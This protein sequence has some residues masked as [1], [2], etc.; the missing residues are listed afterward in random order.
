MYR[1]LFYPTP[2][3]RQ[4][5]RLY[6]DSRDALDQLEDDLEKLGVE[7]HWQ[8]VVGHLEPSDFED[9][10]ERTVIQNVNQMLLGE[11]YGALRVSNGTIEFHIAPQQVM[12]DLRKFLSR[13]VETEPSEVARIP[14]SQK[15]SQS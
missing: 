13:N 6:E 12:D 8:H 11:R 1:L 15:G 4:D 14:L 2:R 10:L 9:D 3:F 5:D 7:L